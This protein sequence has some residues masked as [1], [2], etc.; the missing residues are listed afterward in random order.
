[1]TNRRT[2]RRARPT[3]LD[4]VTDDARRIAAEP[5]PPTRGRVENAIIVALTA[6]I[7]VPLVLILASPF[8]WLAVRLIRWAIS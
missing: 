3:E 8:L 4:R 5:P 6:S 2:P 7:M 1:M